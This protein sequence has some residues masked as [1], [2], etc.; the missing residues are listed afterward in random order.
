MN[1]RYY[2]RLVF[3]AAAVL[4]LNGC[5]IAGEARLGGGPINGGS[6]LDPDDPDNIRAYFYT[7]RPVVGLRYSCTRSGAVPIVG[8][9]GSNG[10][11]VC[12]RNRTV[13][14]FVG[15]PEE[16]KLGQIELSI[17]GA[18]AP[19]DSSLESRANVAI[20]PGTLEGTAVDGGTVLS[21]DVKTN[22]VA[23]IFNL[24]A[25]FNIYPLS[26][27]GV[28][29]ALD[30][31]DKIVLA[32]EVYD[33]DVI[34]LHQALSNAGVAL[35]NLSLEPIS[36]GELIQDMAADIEALPGIQL[37]LGGAALPG[38]DARAQAS[39]AIKA[40][41][42]GLYT[43][44]PSTLAAT[45]YDV[46]DGNSA[47]FLNATFGVLVGRRGHTTGMGY[48]WEIDRTI[49][50]AVEQVFA[51]M[52]LQ[53]GTGIN[54]D[55]T[56]RDNFTFA[57]EDGE[58]IT[59]TQGRL[60]NDILYSNLFRLD[61]D[62]N[63]LVPAAY[64]VSS[65]DLGGFVSLDDRYSGQAQMARN[66]ALELLPDIDLDLIPAGTLPAFVRIQYKSY[67]DGL[68]LTDAQRAD[69]LAVA[70]EVP[71]PPCPNS[72]YTGCV[73]A[74]LIDINILP[75]GDIVSDVDGDCTAVHD[76]GNYYEDV[77]GTREYLVGQAANVF[78]TGTDVPVTYLTVFVSVLDPGHP[79]FG[80]QIGVEQ[81]IDAPFGLSPMVYD[82]DAGILRSKVCD[83]EDGECDTAIEWFNTKVFY[84]DVF[85]VVASLLGTAPDDGVTP[86]S[87]FRLPGYLGL[88]TASITRCAV[89]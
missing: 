41:R 51:G 54:A 61:P 78:Q 89:P 57:S 67:P 24:L 35:L 5:D 8:V 43:Y 2:A 33:G 63:F 23:N 72:R 34:E 86:D 50:D 47:R 73:P 52:A 87:Y 28:P 46:D 80:L 14:F 4:L 18:Q 76:A 55:G 39:T 69:A 27:G 21:T 29:L 7:D 3:A 83:P 36:F 48:Y 11:F 79:D 65:E 66:P 58:G 42:A 77:S 45:I 60:V 26:E 70:G 68:T 75:N 84:D 82:T 40:A 38:L 44:T 85:S 30:R 12:P 56:I 19:S 10:D 74:R 37:R 1:T 22:R 88:V 15:D 17:Y 59:I 53:P 31:Q 71:P 49:A 6:D 32:D 16:L 64:V 81:P 62:D 9:T 13:S 20:T 25:T